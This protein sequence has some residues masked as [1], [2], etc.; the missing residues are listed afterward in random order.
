MLS[1][2]ASPT[3]QSAH[4]AVIPRPYEVNQIRVWMRSDY[5]AHSK[6]TL[7]GE[8]SFCS[9]LNNLLKL[10]FSVHN[11]GLSEGRIPALEMKGDGLAGIERQ[12]LNGEMA[13]T[14][15]WATQNIASFFNIDT[16]AVPWSRA[17]MY[18]CNSV[19]ASIPFEAKRGLR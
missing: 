6:L 19:A 9:A 7:S 1:I 8:R 12:E 18:P 3:V 5:R 4:T 11:S 2:P 10:L 15:G 17:V 13:S 16:S 14:D